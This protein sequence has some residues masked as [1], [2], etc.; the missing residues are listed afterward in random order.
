MFAMLMHFAVSLPSQMHACPHSDCMWFVQLSPVHAADSHDP[1]LKES[2]CRYNV[3]SCS[4]PIPHYFTARLSF[5]LLCATGPSYAH[6]ACLLA[7]SADSLQTSAGYL[8][9][10]ACTL[11]CDNACTLKKVSPTAAVSPRGGQQGH[12]GRCGQRRQRGQRGQRGHAASICRAA[13]ACR[14]RTTAVVGA[15]TIYSTS[16]VLRKPLRRSL[17]VATPPRRCA[18][19]AAPS[20]QLRRR[21]SIVEPYRRSPI[22]MTPSEDSSSQLMFS[23]NSTG[24]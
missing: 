7:P 14:A 4:V 18:L 6:S 22:A 12:R 19:A 13:G 17:I 16:G 1:W 15:V 20:L 21:T 11:T 5:H 24:F 8:G 23:L 9:C 10:S 3:L 2:T